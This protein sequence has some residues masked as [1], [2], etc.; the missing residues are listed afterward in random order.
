MPVLPLMV[1]VPGHPL[2]H[3]LRVRER[4]AGESRHNAR[5]GEDFQKRRGIVGTH[6]Q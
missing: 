4:D 1:E 2:V 6:L 3:S 5:I